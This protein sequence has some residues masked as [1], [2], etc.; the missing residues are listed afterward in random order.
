MGPPW[1]QLGCPTNTGAPWTRE[2]IEEALQRGPHQSAMSPEAIEH[3]RVEAAEKEAAGQCQIYKWDDI[4]NDI[5]KEMK[6]S[7]IAAIPHTRQRHFG[8][9]LICPLLYDL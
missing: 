7:T 5:P 4:K 3:F 9:F 6:L 8:Q 1:S 2:E